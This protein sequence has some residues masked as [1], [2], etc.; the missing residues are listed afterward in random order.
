[1]IHYDV[2]KPEL[3]PNFTIDDIHKIRYWNYERFKDA[4]M[5]ERMEYYDKQAKESVKELGLTNIKFVDV[6]ELNIVGNKVIF[7]FA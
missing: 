2:S 1:M 3:S 6:D 4:T 7:D 5:K